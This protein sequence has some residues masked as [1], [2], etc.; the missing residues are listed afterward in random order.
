MKKFILTT[1]ITILSVCYIS[2]VSAD[3]H[4]GGVK[5][6]WGTS[7][8]FGPFDIRGLIPSLPADQ[9]RD[10][11]IPISMFVI[12]HPKGLIVYDSGN[13]VAI[14]DALDK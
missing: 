10:I 12:D 11:T 8:F 6:Y 5:V 3:G 9:S 1:L 7:G 2:S 4:K 13:N 14:S